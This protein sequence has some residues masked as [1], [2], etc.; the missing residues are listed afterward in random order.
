MH[1]NPKRTYINQFHKKTEDSLNN[2]KK[3]LNKYELY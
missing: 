3:N 1:L 2:S